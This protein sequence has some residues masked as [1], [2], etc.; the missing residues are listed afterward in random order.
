MGIA[1]FFLA[2][3]YQKP[4]N[5]S[6]VSYRIV[7]GSSILVVFIGWVLFKVFCAT[8]GISSK[9]LTYNRVQAILK[10]QVETPY[11]VEGAIRRQLGLALTSLDSQWTLY[12]TVFVADPEKTIPGVVVG[13]GGVFP[14]QIVYSDPHKRDFI[15]PLPSLVAG[16]KELGKQLN[17]T[18]KPVLVFLRNRNHYHN[19]CEGVHNLT[20]QEFYAYLTSRETELTGV[21][22]ASV[23]QALHRLSNLS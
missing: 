16:S 15:D 6:G 13:P 11:D 3:F 22:L 19:E 23:R 1:G 2:F 20:T 8:L 14:I 18:V 5:A 7:Q 10:N 17:R 12:P 9:K 21:E 4:I